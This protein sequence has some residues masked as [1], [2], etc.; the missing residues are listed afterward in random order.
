MGY[1][2]LGGKE[3]VLYEDEKCK[4]G[5]F[6]L[7]DGFHD[8]KMRWDSE[9]MIGIAIVGKK[10]IDLRRIISRMRGARPWHPLLQELRREAEA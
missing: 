7:T 8:K 5:W 1:C 4:P 9:K 6:K 10:D 3:Y 2:I